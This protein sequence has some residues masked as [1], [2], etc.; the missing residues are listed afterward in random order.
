VRFGGCKGVLALHPPLTGRR[1][2]YRPSMQKFVSSHKG[3]EVC[4]VAWAIPCYLNRH[5]ILLM[6]HNGVG[7][8]VFLTLQ[9]EMVRKLDAMVVDGQ[10]AAL[11]LPKLGGVQPWCVSALME[12]VLGGW[13]PQRE[14]FLGQCLEAVRKHHLT[15]LKMRSRVLVPEGKQLMG[16]MDE[17][18][19]LQPGEVFVQVRCTSQVG[20]AASAV[21]VMCWLSSWLA[22]SYTGYRFCCCCYSEVA[23]A[24][25]LV[26]AAGLTRPIT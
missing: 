3:L 19:V 26:M 25:M 5:V 24:A 8:D 1:I 10:A 7:G 6:S 15:E 12:M 4:S 11:L 2:C 13:E 18:G 23:M 21:F 22:T 16:V 17:F 9:R 14:P 20:C